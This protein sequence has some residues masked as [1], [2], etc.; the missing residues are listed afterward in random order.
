MGAERLETPAG[1]VFVRYFG[2]M[3][4]ALRALGGSGTVKEVVNQ[5]ALDLK[6]PTEVQEELLPSGSPRFQNQVQ[7]AKLYLLK[8]GLLSNSKRGIWSLTDVGQHME[9]TMEDAQQIF[10]KQSEQFR[11]QRIQS[12]Q[13]KQLFGTEQDPTAN[14][15]SVSVTVPPPPEE[16][17]QD[18]VEVTHSGNHREEVLAILRG[19]P[20]DSFERFCQLLLREAGFTEV[21]VTGKSGDGGID[22]YGTLEVNP[23]VSFKV[24]FQCKRYKD[25]VSP[26]YVR[27]FR[28]AMQGRADKGLILT[29]GT[30]TQG[31]V[32]EASRDGVPPIELIDAQRLITLMEKFEF[33][34]E[35][36]QTFQVDH[37]FF[38][39][40]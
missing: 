17:E 36:V 29:T 38:K 4:D 26:H 18:A 14:G 1:A 21:K 40:F 28:G 25:V 16:F 22:G 15:L 9:L 10:R 12:Q 13:S 20:A 23:L 31:A 3:L 32:E 30:F 8:A 34:L 11:Q 27:D 6:I 37:K 39:D 33:G 7:W 2:P 35:P 5:I 24:L 19:I